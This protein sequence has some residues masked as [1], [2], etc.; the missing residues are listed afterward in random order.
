[1]HRF[2]DLCRDARGLKLD[3]HTRDLISKAELSAW[4]CLSRYRFASPDQQR[5]LLERCVE[6]EKRVRTA[7]RREHP[8]DRMAA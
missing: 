7:I 2:L 6:L 5:R 8:R 3:P 1:L 4:A